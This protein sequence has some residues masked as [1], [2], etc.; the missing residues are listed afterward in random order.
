MDNKPDRIIWHHSADTS[1]GHQA[2][3]INTYHKKQ[4]FTL[5]ELGFYGG[6]HILIEKDGSIF[7]YRNDN[8]IGCHAKNANINTLGVCMAGNFSIE[9]PTK[10]Q[11][12]SMSQILRLWTVRYNIEATQIIPHRKV[13]ATE[14]PGKLLP[15]DWPSKILQNETPATTQEVL[16]DIIK[17]IQSK[18]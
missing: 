18:L 9:Q 7:R 12:S 2:D 4:G 15:D 10:A 8:E 1:S 17:Y 6:Y 16:L 3:K 11:E 5:S 14:C 13:G